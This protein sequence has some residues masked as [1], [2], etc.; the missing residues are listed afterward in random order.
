MV[1][2]RFE[3]EDKSLS[4]HLSSG[5]DRGTKR[6]ARWQCYLMGTDVSIYGSK[7]V[8]H[9]FIESN[10]RGRLFEDLKNENF[11]NTC[12]WPDISSVGHSTQAVIKEF[13]EARRKRY[14]I[15][16]SLK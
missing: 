12:I 7:Q 13:T 10:G 1:V 14:R 9:V 4:T 2:Y 11:S 8:F 3:N 15:R 5:Q 16:N 6:S